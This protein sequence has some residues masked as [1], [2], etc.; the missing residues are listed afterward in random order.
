M[1]KLVLR[2]QGYGLLSAKAIGRIMDKNPQITTLDLCMNNINLGLDL[3]ISALKKNSSIVCLKLK[4]N[5]IDGR[6]FTED[7]YSL[8]H[9][10][11]SLTALDLGNSENIKNRNR[12]YNEGLKAI[13]EGMA[14]SADETCLISELHLQSS[15]ITGKGLQILSML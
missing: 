4:N 5:N 13:I 15:C 7:L 3:L 1:S 6:R 14:D 8:V 9:E 12:I 11:P 10:H 2:E